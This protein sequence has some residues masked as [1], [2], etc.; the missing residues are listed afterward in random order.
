MFFQFEKVSHVVMEWC[1]HNYFFRIRNDPK[2]FP[3]GLD[4]LFY[5]TDGFKKLFF[6]FEN[7][8][9]RKIETHQIKFS[10]W[11]IENISLI[12]VDSHFQILCSSPSFLERCLIWIAHV[13]VCPSMSPFLKITSAPTPNI[14]NGVTFASHRL[15]Q[16]LLEGVMSSSDLFHS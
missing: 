11:T 14:Q 3:P 16:F 8:V 15:N 10:V 5:F 1:L 13:Y 12:K 7:V 6:R 2:K 4:S 9:Q